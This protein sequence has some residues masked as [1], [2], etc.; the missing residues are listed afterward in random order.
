M[1]DIYVRSLKQYLWHLLA[2]T[3][4]GI[5]RIQIIRLL[6]ERPYNANQ[7][8]E[9]LQLDYKTVQH[10]LRVL[11]KRNIITTQDERSYGSM[12]FISPLMEE[13]M[14]LFEEILDK[15]GKNKINEEIDR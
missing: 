1:D 11:L 9:K 7:I 5:T 8:H 10:H 12:Y 14:N 3:K 13:N 6:L 2:G 4:G 15:I